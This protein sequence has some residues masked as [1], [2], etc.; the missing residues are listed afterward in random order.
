MRY[1]AL[2][3]ASAVFSARV[4]ADD[5]FVKPPKEA[6]SREELIQIFGVSRGCGSVQRAEFSQFG[7]KI[8]AVWYDP[9][10]GRAA[11]YLHAY[12]YDPQKAAWM[13]F[14]DRIIEGAS[15]LSAEMPSGRDVL[16]IRDSNAKVLLEEALAKFPAEKWWDQKK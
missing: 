10:S 8:L 5:A 16:V 14:I 15:D 13:L 3:L 7:K 11:C 12:Y 6:K 4:L 1:L 9:F 2:V